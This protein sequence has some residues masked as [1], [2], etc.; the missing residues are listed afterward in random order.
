MEKSCRNKKKIERKRTPFKI[1]VN[2][3]DSKNPKGFSM[4]KRKNT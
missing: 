1:N 3:R 4:K 2:S